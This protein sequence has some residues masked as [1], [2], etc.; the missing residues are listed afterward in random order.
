MPRRSSEILA[1]SK[2]QPVDAYLTKDKIERL[3]RE[4]IDIQTRQ[5][6]EALEELKRTQEMGDL[7]ENAAYQEA[8][9]TLRRLNARIISIQERLKHA[10]VIE[11]T[12]DGTVQIGSSVVVEIDGVQRTFEIVGEQETDP[13]RGRI[14]FKSPIGMALIGK[15]SGDAVEIT[16]QDRAK[17]VHI[18]QICSEVID[19]T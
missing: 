7:S 18:L 11:P 12:N 9:W 6:P 2:K 13:T 8:K 19:K 10:I 16:I 3:K 4:L 15:R 14:S 5:Q 17:T 1:Q